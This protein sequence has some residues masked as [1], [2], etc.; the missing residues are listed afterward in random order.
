MNK[1]YLSILLVFLGIVTTFAQDFKVGTTLTDKLPAPQA[2]EYVFGYCLEE[3]TSGIQADTPADGVDVAFAIY[4]PESISKQL[5]GNMINSLRIAFNNR[6]RRD[7]A[8]FIKEDINGEDDYVEEN[9]RLSTVG[10]NEVDLATPYEIN[11]KGFYVGYRYHYYSSYTVS[12]AQF[13]MST[14]NEN[15][16][17]SNLNNAGWNNTDL[18]EFGALSLQIVMSG[19]GTLGADAS[20]MDIIIPTSVKSESEFTIQSIVRNY[21]GT[22]INAYDLFYSVDGGEET[23]INVTGKSIQPNGSDTTNIVLSIAEESIGEHSVKVRLE[24]EGDMDDTNNE[25]TK[26]LI[27][28]TTP[29]S[30]KVLI[31]DF[32]GMECSFCAEASEHIDHYLNESGVADKAVIVAHHAYKGSYYD[33]YALENSLSYASFFGMTGAPQMMIDRYG[34]GGNTLMFDVLNYNPG[35]MA[36]TRLNSDCFTSIGIRSDYNKATRELTI[37]VVGQKYM[38]LTGTYP[39][40]HV[41]LTEDGQVNW[42]NSSSGLIQNYVH[43]HVLRVFVTDVIG[44][45]LEPEAGPYERTYT[46]T[47]PEE[48]YGYGGANGSEARPGGPT[49]LNDENM[50]I[51]AFVGNFNPEV[52]TD[53]EVINANICEIGGE[54]DGVES[55]QISDDC[56]VYAYGDNI[57][58]EGTNVGVDIYSLTGTLVKSVN[59]TVSVV[60]ASDLEGGLYIVK[61][62]TSVSGNGVVKKVLVK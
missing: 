47:I 44:D 53:C 62:K 43:D 56:N 21:G 32:T 41:W 46:V 54:V 40:L 59:T 36:T 24:L 26:T 57:Y 48:I 55:A 50:H 38:P 20:M 58:V 33:F 45:L 7:V 6:Y 60:D 18:A 29:V 39:T 19:S 4:I 34:F 2:D 35:A 61:V 5:Q 31:E 10:W 28:Y 51:V 9:L 16:C 11:G 3:T 30:K 13:D 23:E 52:P 37:T 42:Q 12:M 8:I 1:I 25:L 17:W 27:V 22:E 14:F 15:A 49:K